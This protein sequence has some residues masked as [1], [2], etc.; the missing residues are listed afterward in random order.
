MG[1]D[2]YQSDQERAQDMQAGKPPIGIGAQ[3]VI[4][5]AIIDKNAHIGKNVQIINKDNTQKAEHEDKGY[6][7]RNGIVVVLKN[8]VIPDGTII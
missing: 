7:I 1:A 8:A 5:N 3:T 4:R 6:W 2:I